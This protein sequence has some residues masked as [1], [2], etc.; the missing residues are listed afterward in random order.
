MSG[1]VRGAKTERSGRAEKCS[2]KPFHF[3]LPI[4]FALRAASANLNFVVQ[5]KFSG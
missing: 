5:G 1:G 2:K 4:H 3:D